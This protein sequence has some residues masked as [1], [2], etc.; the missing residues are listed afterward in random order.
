MHKLYIQSRLCTILTKP[1]EDDLMTLKSQNQNFLKEKFH[2]RLTF[3]PIERKL[4]GHDIAA[5][6]NLVKPLIGNTLI[7]AG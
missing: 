7:R 4:Y 6:P 1:Q 3:D 2:N 5:I